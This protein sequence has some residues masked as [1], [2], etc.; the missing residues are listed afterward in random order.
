MTQQ[1]LEDLS[2]A[3]QHARA[4]HTSVLTALTLRGYGLPMASDLVTRG[5]FLLLHGQYGVL[6]ELHRARQALALAY[7]RLNED[8]SYLREDLSRLEGEVDALL[9]KLDTEERLRAD[10]ELLG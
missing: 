6:V 2:E 10:R 3:V 4:H 7:A 9:S 5:L 1:E 8:T